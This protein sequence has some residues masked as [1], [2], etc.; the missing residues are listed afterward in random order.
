[1]TKWSE[2][3]DGNLQ[4]TEDIKKCFINPPDEFRPVPWLCY[5]GEMTEEEIVYAI[6][7]MYEQ[8]I[9]SFFIDHTGVIRVASDQNVTSTSDP[10]E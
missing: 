9:R 2:F 10:L 3:D 4:K 6:E 8:G 1:M 7:Q 5:T